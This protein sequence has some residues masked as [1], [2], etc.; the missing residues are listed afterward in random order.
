MARKR[1]THPVSGVPVK[2]GALPGDANWWTGFRQLEHNMAVSETALQV[3][4]KIGDKLLEGP[5]FFKGPDEECKEVVQKNRPV[6]LMGKERVLDASL[7]QATMRV[8]YMLVS[9]GIET[10]DVGFLWCNDGGRC[11]RRQGRMLCG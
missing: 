2:Q 10:V 5:M 11:G 6:V 8:S 9:F 3:M 1:Q 4:E 7:A